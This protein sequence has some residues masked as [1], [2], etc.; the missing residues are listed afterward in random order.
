LGEYE[1][2]LSRELYT[3]GFLR[4]VHPWVP[5]KVTPVGYSWI[6]HPWVIPGLYTRGYLSCVTPWVSLLCYTRGLSRY[7][8]WV[9]PVS[10]PWVIPVSLVVGNSVVNGAHADQCCS[11][12]GPCAGCS[13]QCPKVDNSVTYGH[14]SASYSRSEHLLY[15]VGYT[16]GGSPLSDPENK[17]FSHRKQG[18]EAQETR[19]RKH[20][21]TRKLGI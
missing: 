1:G 15:S 17:P 2:G 6:T 14:P 8:P 5:E 19:Y 9:I 21:C 18:R 7:H 11:Y 16:G 12:H 10:H 3:R 13:S 20:L 4:V